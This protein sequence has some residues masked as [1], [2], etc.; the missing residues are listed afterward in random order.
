M[1][2]VLPTIEL[3]V[4]GDKVS[5]SRIGLGTLGM[6][7][8]YEPAD[9]DESVKVLNHAIDIGC[10]FWD[11]ANIYG[12]G[13]N[14]RLLSRVLKE[15]RKDVFLCTKFGFQYRVPEPGE[16][17]KPNDFVSGVSGKP[18]FVRKCFEE[19]LER[20]G[21]D[22]IDLY[23]MH[24]MD[25]DTSIEDTIAAM[26]ELVKEGRVRYLGLSNCVADDLRRAYAVHP[27]AAVQMPYSA[28]TTRIETDGLLDAC[29]E[30]D[31][32]VIAHSPLGAGALT[33]TITSADSLSD[34]DTRLHFLLFHKDKL[35][36]AINLVEAFG[37]VTEKHGCTPSQVA[38][39]WLLAKDNVI[40]IPGTKGIE[41]LD[42]NCAAAQITLSDEEI[43]ELNQK[44]AENPM[45]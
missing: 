42:Q 1:S 6:S 2:P 44:A 8:N 22:T 38:L 23:Y 29:R 35:Q 17:G 4:P 30:L 41:H 27:I 5:V 16:K 18:D 32:T 7:A 33:G 9:D 28:W 11:T 39:A 34:K 26:A 15:R 14:E 3:G 19:S 25:P 12:F 20:L 24:R 40:P 36:S 43:A 13:H 21:V 31:V 45:Y 10:T 37:V